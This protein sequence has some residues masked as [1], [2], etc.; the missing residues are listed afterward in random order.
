MPAGALGTRL[1]SV[2]GLDMK[3]FDVEVAVCEP[4]LQQ[5]GHVHGLFTRSESAE[6]PVLL[7]DYVVD[8]HDGPLHLGFI[9]RYGLISADSSGNEGDVRMPA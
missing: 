7:I 3:F 8:G 2:D 4:V 5:A 1:R 6:F 9:G